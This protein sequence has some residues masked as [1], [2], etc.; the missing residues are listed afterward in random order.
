M[1]DLARRSTLGDKAG[2]LWH[3]GANFN[4]CAVTDRFITRLQW[5]P[6]TDAEFSRLEQLTLPDG[7]SRSAG[8]DPRVF[9]CAPGEWLIVS[10]NLSADILCKALGGLSNNVNYAVTDAG[11]GLGC[12]RIAGDGA[13]PRIAAGC[14]APLEQTA[15]GCYMLTRLFALPALIHKVDDSPAFDLY[16]DRSTSRYLW[17]CLLV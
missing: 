3:T 12:I 17:D 4:L 15:A 10:T 7:P 8:E 16:I 11:C 1:A 13:L 5:R 9:W 14:S 6:G 2:V